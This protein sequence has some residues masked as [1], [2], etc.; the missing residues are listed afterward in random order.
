MKKVIILSAINLALVAG[1][2]AQQAPTPPPSQPAGENHQRQN[3]E[4][5]REMQPPEIRA[6]KKVEHL[7]KELGLNGDQQ[8]KIF[9]S[10][11]NFFKQR[12]ALQKN[13]ESMDKEQFHQKVKEIEEL[14]KAQMKSILTP[15]QFAKVQKQMEENKERKHEGGEPHRG[16]EAPNR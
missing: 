7:S 6:K 2:F 1:V 5:E 11:V 9:A 12:D 4:Q 14:R 10:E 13:K 3:G 15:E 16:D 8:S